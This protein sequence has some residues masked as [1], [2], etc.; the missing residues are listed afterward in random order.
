MDELAGVIADPGRLIG[1]RPEGETLWQWQARAVRTYLESP[2][3]VERAAELLW[4]TDTVG[5]AWTE[6]DDIV[7]DQYRD[8]ARA[9]LQ[10]A[11]GKQDGR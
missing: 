8:S 4:L 5:G 6:A 11:G 1:V 7:R 10:A 3:V 9:A 2:E